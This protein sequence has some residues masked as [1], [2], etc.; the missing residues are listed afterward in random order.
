[1]CDEERSRHHQFVSEITVLV[2]QSLENRIEQIVDEVDFLN[3]L[4]SEGKIKPFGGQTGL[5]F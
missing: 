1:M 3:T 2:E 4:S 5:F